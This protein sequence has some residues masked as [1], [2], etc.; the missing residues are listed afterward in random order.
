MQ[1]YIRKRGHQAPEPP[2]FLRLCFMPR[3]SA[4]ER[5]CTASDRNH[6]HFIW[7]QSTTHCEVSRPSLLSIG[8]CAW[9]RLKSIAAAATIQIVKIA[10]V[11]YLGTLSRLNAIL[12]PWIS[13]HPP[14]L[15][16]C[17]VHRPWALFCE[18]T[19][20][21]NGTDSWYIILTTCCVLTMSN[22]WLICGVG[23]ACSH[24][25]SCTKFNIP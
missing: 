16:Q 6:A 19:V 20:H 3:F 5:S 24:A 23:H 22:V 14:V 12:I 2:W 10:W 9:I 11:T 13:A 4:N 17:K 15:A 8:N 21:V 1:L 25:R 18:G 7:L